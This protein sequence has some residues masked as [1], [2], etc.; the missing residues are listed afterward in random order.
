MGQS[1]MDEIY[2]SPISH[3]GVAVFTQYLSRDD[4]LNGHHYMSFLAFA[5]DSV[6]RSPFV[7]QCNG[8]IVA[9]LLDFPHLELLQVILI[10]V[11]ISY[12]LMFLYFPLR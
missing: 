1:W 4:E 10:V 8:L 7:A 12:S 9:Q 6:Y 3:G 5:A 2:R 11:R